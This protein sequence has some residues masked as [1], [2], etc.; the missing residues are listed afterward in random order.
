MKLND[1]KMIKSF[2]YRDLT[3]HRFSFQ[4]IRESVLLVDLHRK[5]FMHLPI[6][7]QAYVGVGTLSKAAS[8]LKIGQ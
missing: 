5:L 1:T 6:D 7:A 4:R 8:Y 2:E 3:L